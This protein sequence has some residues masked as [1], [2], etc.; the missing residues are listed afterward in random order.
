MLMDANFPVDL[1]ALFFQHL[2]THELLQKRT[3]GKRINAFIERVAE[4]ALKEIAKKLGAE[5][6]HHTQSVLV[7]SFKAKHSGKEPPKSVLYLKIMTQEARQLLTFCKNTEVTKVIADK[8]PQAA[9]KRSNDLESAHHVRAKLNE[10]PT[11]STATVYFDNVQLSELPPEVLKF[12][13]LTFISLFKNVFTEFPEILLRLPKL[14]HINLC[15][16]QLKKIPA[17]ISQATQLVS[18]KLNDNQLEEMPA[19]LAAIKTLKLLTVKN[20]KL[21]KLPEEYAAIDFEKLD[22]S[23][24]PGL[25]VP[26]GIH[27]SHTLTL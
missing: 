17:A 2:P 24:N 4:N 23:G 10:A 16:N 6:Y 3:T 27:A 9:S 26:N 8:T 1:G 22:A 19:E 11:P 15:K 13:K 21:K 25:V 7:E 18:L 5:R 20:N 12:E 14:Q